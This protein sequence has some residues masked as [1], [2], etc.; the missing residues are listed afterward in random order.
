MIL[1]LMSFFNLYIFRALLFAHY[2]Q[3]A[4][5][6]LRNHLFATQHDNGTVLTGLADM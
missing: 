1:I 4:R 2:A 6:H 3:D 5:K